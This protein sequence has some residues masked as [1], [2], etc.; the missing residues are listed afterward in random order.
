[1]AGTASSW[2]QEPMPQTSGQLMS[3]AHSIFSYHLRA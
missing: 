3:S 2:S 1:M